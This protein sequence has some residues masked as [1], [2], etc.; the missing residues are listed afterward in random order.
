MLVAYNVNPR[1]SFYLV[2][3]ICQ[4]SFYSDLE[5]MIVINSYDWRIIIKAYRH[6]R[7]HSSLNFHIVAFQEN[8]LARQLLTRF[9]T[10]KQFALLWQKIG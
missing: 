1:V 5:V 2:L 9:D 7:I 10:D 6:T 8:N 3:I 4:L